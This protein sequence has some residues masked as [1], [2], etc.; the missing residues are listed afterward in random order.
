MQIL[1]EKMT[2]EQFVYWL[3]GFMEIQD[4]TKLTELQVQMIKDHL[5]LVFN[6]KTPIY[7]ISRTDT[8]SGTVLTFPN[9]IQ[10]SH[11]IC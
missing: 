5:A 1:E 11:F 3:Q 7:S 2:P 8:S 10:S 6:K 4:P 9:N